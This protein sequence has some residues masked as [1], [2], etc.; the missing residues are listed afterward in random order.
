LPF[1][2]NSSF[3]IDFNAPEIAFAYIIFPYASPYAFNALFIF[4]PFAILI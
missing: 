2:I 3:P 1:S 4:Y